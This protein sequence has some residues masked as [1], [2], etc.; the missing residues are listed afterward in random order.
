MCEN[1]KFKKYYDYNNLSSAHSFVKQTLLQA[2]SKNK[3][4]PSLILPCSLVKCYH[5]SMG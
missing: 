3:S 1:K 4:R 5:E 2:V